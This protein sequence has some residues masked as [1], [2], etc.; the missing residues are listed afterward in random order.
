MLYGN[1]DKSNSRSSMTNY[2]FMM[3]NAEEHLELWFE[4]SMIGSRLGPKE[5]TTIVCKQIDGFY[6]EYLKEG[7]R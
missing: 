6:I 1:L 5:G 7:P 4:G 2:Q 3:L